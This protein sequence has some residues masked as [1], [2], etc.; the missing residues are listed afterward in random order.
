MLRKFS[1][2]LLIS[3]SLLMLFVGKVDSPF[4]HAVR[5]TVMDYYTSI[6]QYAMLPV[7][8]VREAGDVMGDYFSVYSKN[9][10]L[11][12][13][14]RQLRKGLA[15]LSGV[16]VENERLK[17]LLRFVG[18]RPYTLISTNV[19]GDAS[20]P[21]LRTLLIN[22]GEADGIEKGLAVIGAE[23]LVGRTLATGRV[24]SQVLLITDINSRVPVKSSLARERGV[25]A[26][27]NT[28]Y[29]VLFYLP[30]D[31]KLTEGEEVLTSGDGGIFPP[32]IP[33]GIVILDR[34]GH[35]CVK[36]YVVA[37]RLEH[38]S[39]IRQMEN[40]QDGT[41]ELFEPLLSEPYSTYH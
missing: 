39:V 40:G 26:G 5:V 41:D 38:V 15:L 4:T 8:V 18:N 12:H 11:M 9:R 16:K 21:F 29:P 10:Q 6:A 22:G 36:P 20:G 34:S 28:P 1:F 31:T 19:V 13:E 25:L 3:L 23:G 37:S 33:V 27:N 14:N 35:F 30:K 17:A 32:D 2:A 24:S 7:E